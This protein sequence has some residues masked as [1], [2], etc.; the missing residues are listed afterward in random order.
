L[1]WAGRSILAAGRT[2]SGVHASGQVIAFDLE[3][4][5]STE[6]LGR[7]INAQLPLD[8]AVRK[9]QET[10]AE[11]HPRF[12]AVQRT[13]HYQIHCD[14]ARDPLRERYYWRVWPAV[15]EN[16]LVQAAQLLTGTYDFAAFGAPPR[17]G[18]STVR[19]VYKASWKPQAGGLLF[20]ISANAYLY[21]MV[22]RAVFMQV[23]VGQNRLS[24]ADL[25]EAVRK[26]KPQ[27]PGL[28]PPQG[29]SLVEVRYLVK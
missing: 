10:T 15:D 12:D 21:H 24:L 17:S 1:S 4:V 18:G 20:E 5:H 3:W 22:R 14:A 29:L 16:L 6:A 25:S 26:A 11:F 27:T 2:D 19:M 7:A 9:I 13:Y 8:V 28:A 23:L